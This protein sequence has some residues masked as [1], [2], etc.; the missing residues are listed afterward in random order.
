MIKVYLKTKVNESLNLSQRTVAL[1]ISI[2]NVENYDFVEHESFHFM[3]KNNNEINRM[4][5]CISAMFMALIY[6]QQNERLKQHFLKDPKICFLADEEDYDFIAVMNSKLHDWAKLDTKKI[7]DCGEKMTHFETGGNSLRVIK[8]I[9]FI[10]ACNYLDSLSFSYVVSNPNYCWY[11]SNNNT[12]D[13]FD[14]NQMKYLKIFLN[15]D[16]S[17]EMD[18]SSHFH[19]I[20]SMDNTGQKRYHETV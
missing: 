16:F 5:S 1:K 4:R 3:A 7:F 19:H 10:N 9:N 20:K 11:H 18:D 14:I 8:M 15:S 12:K 17:M 13:K 6:I 2:V